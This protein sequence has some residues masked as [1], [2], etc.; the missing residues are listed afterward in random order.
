MFDPYTVERE[1]GRGGMGV[2]YQARDPR[3]DRVVAIK[4]SVDDGASLR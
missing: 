4:L 1:I 2:I 3:L